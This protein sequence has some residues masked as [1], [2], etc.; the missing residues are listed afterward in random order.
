MEKIEDKVKISEYKFLKLFVATMVVEK[1]GRFILKSK[2]QHDLLKVYD[3]KDLHFLFEDVCKKEN[4]DDSYVDL[5]EAFLNAQAFGL[6]TMIHDADTYI[7][8]VI[9]LSEKDAKYLMSQFSENEIYA[10]ISLVHQ[11]NSETVCQK[12]GHDFSKWKHN[13]W[14]VID[15]LVVGK[16]VY[17]NN[18]C[19]ENWERTCKRCGFV[20][21]V[22]KN[23]K[24]LVKKLEL[25]NKNN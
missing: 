12:N 7:K 3:N 6:L 11:L 24:E 17:G 25:V 20:E 14:T 13:E 4:V 16:C 18:R 1:Y 21:K 15:Q 2:L 19:C 8:Y 22:D 9:N 23:P 5:N 10:M